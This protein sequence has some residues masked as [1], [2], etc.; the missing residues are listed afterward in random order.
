M[1][2]NIYKME[3][4]MRK[5]LIKILF[6]LIPILIFTQSNNGSVSGTVF[7]DNEPL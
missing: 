2:K 4:K 1:L 7:G 5:H 3:L 6:P